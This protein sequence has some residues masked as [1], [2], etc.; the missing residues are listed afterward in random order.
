M[1]S[2]MKFDLADMACELYRPKAN[3][4]CVTTALPE[5]AAVTMA[6]IPFQLDKTTYTP[7]MALQEG[8]LFTTLNK[9]FNGRSLCNE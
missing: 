8:T 7:E 5:D 9:P 4:C 3:F 2:K 1:D 6:Y